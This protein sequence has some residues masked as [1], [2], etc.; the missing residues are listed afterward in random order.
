MEKEGRKREE[1]GLLGGS[2]YILKQ[3]KSTR[4]QNPQRIPHISAQAYT[5][6]M[7]GN[8]HT[9]LILPCYLLA[10]AFVGTVISCMGS[11]HPTTDSGVFS[12]QHGLAVSVGNFWAKAGCYVVDNRWVTPGAALRCV[13][14]LSRNH[15][16]TVIS[17]KSPELF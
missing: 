8:W 17:G 10:R 2:S 14:V 6:S 9:P 3:M 5:T 15:A 13:E 16:N 4:V 11:L 1:G 7:H 12:L